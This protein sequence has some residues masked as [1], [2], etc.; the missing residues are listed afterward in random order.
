MDAGNIADQERDQNLW[1][2]MTD[3]PAALCEV[4]ADPAFL[5]YLA[6]EKEWLAEQS[7]LYA[8]EL[9]QMEECLDVCRKKYDSPVKEIG[10]ILSPI[11][12]VYSADYHLGG[13]C[14]MFSSGAFRMDAV[15]HEFLHHVLHP[16][17]QKMA[18]AVMQNRRE[19]PGVDASYYLAGTDAGQINAFEEYAVRELTR[20]MMEN[21]YPDDLVRYLR[22]RI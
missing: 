16:V 21:R 7:V 3:F 5:R 1:D 2:W 9:R 19:Y 14:F 13:K 22:K 17:V 8:N 12:C 10:L 15:M 20:D 11:K 4:L 6:W 18:D